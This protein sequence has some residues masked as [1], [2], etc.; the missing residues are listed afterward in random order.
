MTVAV[1]VLLTAKTRHACAEY[2]EFYYRMYVLKFMPRCHAVHIPQC[3]PFHSPDSRSPIRTSLTAS[4]SL[5][6]AEAWRKEIVQLHSWCT[7]PAQQVALHKRNLAMHQ[8]TSFPPNLP[9]TRIWARRSTSNTRPVQ[10]GRRQK[11][12]ERYV[13]SLMEE[14]R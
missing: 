7:A 6:P 9:L 14:L 11:G 5:A 2:A 12:W 4:S 1:F 10:P 13:S 3:S 8:C